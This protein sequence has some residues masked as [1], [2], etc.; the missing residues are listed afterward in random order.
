MSSYSATNT[1][2]S[3]DQLVIYGQLVVGPPGSGKTTYCHKMGDYLKAKFGEANVK[4]VNLDPGNDV[5]PYTCDLDVCELITVEDVMDRLKLGPN[6]SLLYC[7]QFIDENFQEGVISKVSDLF[8]NCNK[9][10]PCWLLFDMPGQLELYTHVPAIKSIISKLEKMDYR[11]CCLNFVDS[12]YCSDP[13]KYIACLL[14][15]LTSMLHIALPY[16]NVLS[17]VDL[18][19]KYGKLPFSLDYYTEVLDLE[20][21]T[22]MLDA[23]PLTARY[24]S[25]NSAVASIVENYGLVSFLALDVNNP[26][27]L[28]KVAQAVDKCVGRFV[29]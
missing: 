2:S 26:N 11:L 24:K 12:H 23:D 5:L 18:A 19:E 9:M 29:T 13:G 21:L 6:G 28:T 22:D 27:L 15:C 17:K 3:E 20:Y 10:E 7:M 1:L 16:L 4:L 14:T 25:L 8:K